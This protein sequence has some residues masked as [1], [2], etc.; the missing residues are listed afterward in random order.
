MSAAPT[1]RGIDVKGVS[2]TFKLDPDG[3]HVRRRASPDLA[4]AAVRP[5]NGRDGRRAR[6]AAR[7]GD[8]RRR[9]ARARRHGRGADEVLCLSR[10]AG[11]AGRAESHAAKGA[12]GRSASSRCRRPTRQGASKVKLRSMARAAQLRMKITAEAAGDVGTL[13]VAGVPAR[14]GRC[15]PPTATALTGL[16]GLDRAIAVDKRAGSLVVSARGTSAPTRGSR[17]A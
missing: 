4:E 7:H 10:R 14:S 12:R 13:E 17:R 15:R 9:C 16:L 5:L 1:W 2:G 3:V 8:I 6:R 11:A